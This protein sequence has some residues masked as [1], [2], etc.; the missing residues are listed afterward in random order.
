MSDEDDKDSHARAHLQFVGFHGCESITAKSRDSEIIGK[1]V[2]DDL[3]LIALR[4][5]SFQEY[6]LQAAPTQTRKPIERSAI[7][8]LETV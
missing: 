5:L 3:S 1:L 2:H 7:T 6:S 4:V 8:A